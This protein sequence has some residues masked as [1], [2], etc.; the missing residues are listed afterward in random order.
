MWQKM[1][2]MS[3]KDILEQ[4]VEQFW[5][6]QSILVRTVDGQLLFNI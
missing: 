3:L 2:Y 1:W 5:G 6:H 4:R